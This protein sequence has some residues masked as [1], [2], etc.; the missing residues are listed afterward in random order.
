MG[1]ILSK[2]EVKGDTVIKPKERF[3]QAQHQ[4]NRADDD[5]QLPPLV[6][7]KDCGIQTIQSYPYSSKN[8]SRSLLLNRISIFIL[9]TAVVPYI[10]LCLLVAHSD[11]VQ[12]ILTY[13]HYPTFL[14]HDKELQ[15]LIHRGLISARNVNLTKPD[16]I[17]LRGWHI[18]PMEGQGKSYIAKMANLSLSDTSHIDSFYDSELA[19]GSRPIVI[20]LHGNTNN[21]ALWYRIGQV[22]TLS[23]ILDAHII[24]FDYAGFGDS[25]GWPSEAT[26]ASDA[27]AIFDWVHAIAARNCGSQ[28]EQ[29]GQPSRSP[30]VLLY[31]HSLGSAIA[32]QLAVDLF[33]RAPN[34]GQRDG[35]LSGII[36]D[37]PFATFTDAI[38][39]HP[40][41]A[42]LRIF[43]FVQTYM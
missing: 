37:A 18:M 34:S 24:A 41:S 14:K 36:L 33:N 8:H 43:P 3:N 31:G 21:R 11:V 12:S 38:M 26:T 39:G 4:N 23:S 22:K 6:I 9:L 13:A 28:A 19:S 35:L 16:G 42:F 30:K 1:G 2:G 17:T 29:E 5:T 40:S 10:V 25:E 27:L 7:L 20:Y 32:V 15:D